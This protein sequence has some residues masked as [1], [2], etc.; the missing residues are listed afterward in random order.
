LDPGTGDSPQASTFSIVSLI[1]YAISGIVAAFGGG[2][3]R[4]ACPGR[5]WRPQGRCTV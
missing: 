4:R 1:W 3:S 5:R 2:T